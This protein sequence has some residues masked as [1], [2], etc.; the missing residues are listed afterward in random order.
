MKPRRVESAPLTDEDQIAWLHTLERCPATPMLYFD[1]LE[2]DRRD[3]L[4]M[5]A[6][7][8]PHRCPCCGARFAALESATGRHRTVIHIRA[9]RRALH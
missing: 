7:K 9:H 5:Y 2:C 6:A 8:Q 3:A 4:I 1:S